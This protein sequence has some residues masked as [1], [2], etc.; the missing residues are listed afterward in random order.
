MEVG[1]PLPEREAVEGNIYRN[2]IKI[3]RYEN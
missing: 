1:T 3:K 2:K